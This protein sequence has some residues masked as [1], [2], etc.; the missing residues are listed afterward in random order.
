VGPLGRGKK[1]CLCSVLGV[2][3]ESAAQLV[4]SDQPPGLFAVCRMHVLNHTR[5]G[6]GEKQIYERWALN[7]RPTDQ[8]LQALPL[9]LELV[10]A[11]VA[12]AL[13]RTSVFESGSK[14]NSALYLSCK[15]AIHQLRGP[16]GRGAHLG[17]AS[18]PQTGAGGLAWR[19]GGYGL[20]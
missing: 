19:R 9:S 16:G 3:A 14:L 8:L 4:S 12:M 20:K 5:Q 2:E 15:A 7:Q 6:G 17:P 10:F 13:P 1:I 11:G 18:A